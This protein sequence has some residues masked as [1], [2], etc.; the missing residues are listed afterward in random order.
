MRRLLG[1]D[2]ISLLNPPPACVVL[3]A[4]ARTGMAAAAVAMPRRH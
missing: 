3:D 4:G 2:L 1:R